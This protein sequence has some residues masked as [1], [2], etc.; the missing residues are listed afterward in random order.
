L[1]DLGLGVWT[2]L[3]DTFD[4]D[5]ATQAQI[6]AI[7]EQRYAPVLA[8]IGLTPAAG[9]KPTIATFRPEL[10]SALGRVRDPQV[11][12]EAKRLFAALQ[13]NPDAVSGGLK[14]TWLGIIAANADAATWDQLHAMARNASSATER[15][16]LY[17]LLGSAENEAL[18]KRALDLA[19]TDEPG[20]TVSA[21]IIGAVARQHPDLALDF[22]LAHWPQ[23]QNFVDLSAQSRFIGRIAS[24]S[25]NPATIAKLDAYA[26]AN[27][28]ASDR[29]PIDQAINLIRVRQATEPRIRAETGEWLR[30]H[31]GAAP[32]APATAPAPSQTERG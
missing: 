10:I 9:E 20:K 13:T 17:S 8:Q 23:V 15:Q 14:R 21:G 5:K 3:Y 19:L 31:D 1:S 30:T 24:G 16:N 26:K 7:I 29:K 4:G 18:A 11:T 28:A 6:S 32:A 27:I 25:H 12:A 2:G 22:V